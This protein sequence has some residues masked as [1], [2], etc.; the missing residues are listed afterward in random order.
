MVRKTLITGKT[1]TIG[2]N[3]F[4]ADGPPSS[5]YDLT[6]IRQVKSLLNKYKPNTIIH[7]AA[8]VPSLAMDENMKYSLFYNNIM[9]NSN[10]IEVAKNMEIPRVLSFLSSWAFPKQGNLICDESHTQKDE[11]LELYYPYGYSKRMLEIQSRICYESFG[12]CYN[13]VLP[14]NIY[15]IND[16]FSLSAGHV[17]AMLIHKAFNSK[18]NK[19]DFIVWGDGSQEREFI[20]TDDVVK[21]VKWAI[22][23][24]LEKEPIILSNNISV[25]IKDVAYIIAKRFGV[26]NQLIFD[27]SKPIGQKAIRSDGSK[28][29]KLLDFQFTPIEKGIDIT[30]D[31]FLKNYPNIRF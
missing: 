5:R 18:N 29:K 4:F 31:W 8:R 7:C 10:I 14:T 3:I 24:Y 11:P 17:I 30:I 9:I 2:S 26:T 13:C 23:N 1:G 16:N 21:L 22:D 15:G 12:L 25:S 6:D 19:T 20:F 27:T 28:L